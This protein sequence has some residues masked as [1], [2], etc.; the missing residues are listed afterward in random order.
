MGQLVFR[1]ENYGDDTDDVTPAP[2]AAFGADVEEP[3]VEHSELDPHR[4]RKVHLGGSMTFSAGDA[5]ILV[6]YR[7]F[8]QDEKTMQF[9][10]QVMIEV[11]GT[12]YNTTVDV[13]PIEV[14]RWKKP[15]D[16]HGKINDVASAL[17]RAAAQQISGS[18]ALS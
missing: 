5:E 4:L 1:P 12:R 7:M 18:L 14:Q 8:G 13:D 16:I 3:D 10:L 9:P 15:D 6:R 11:D 17:M 2:P